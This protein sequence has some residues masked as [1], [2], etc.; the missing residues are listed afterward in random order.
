MRRLLEEQTS[1]GRRSRA[2]VLTVGLTALGVLAV[3]SGVAATETTAL[4]A[5]LGPVLLSVGAVGLV[6]GV[7]S[8]VL[9]PHRAVTGA[10]ARGVYRSLATNQDALLSVFDLSA[11]PVYVPTGRDP[12][13]EPVESVRLLALADGATPPST[14]DPHRTV[15]GDGPS[16]RGVALRPCGTAFLATFGRDLTGA[17]S[18]QPERLAAQLADA[19]VE[20]VDL[21]RTVRV[22][23][24]SADDTLRFR[25]RDGVFG[26]TGRDNPVGSFLASG[27]AV[28]LERPV[29]LSTDRTDGSEAILTCRLLDGEATPGAATSAETDPEAADG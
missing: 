19:A 17:P 5:A 18:D 2:V 27:L 9:V 24:T 10:T 8:W 21:A 12:T 20:S 16:N 15:L 7:L 25:V 28:V 4:D 26:S 14:V 23:P 1:E 3:A 22:E 6:G 11:D 13:T 29:S